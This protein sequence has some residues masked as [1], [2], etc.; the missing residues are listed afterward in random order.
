MARTAIHKRD[1]KRYLRAARV[2]AVGLALAAG[3]LWA[4]D[5]PGVNRA[6][7]EPSRVE[8]PREAP[9]TQP[10]LRPVSL[11]RESMEGVATRLEL[12]T[13]HKPAEAGPTG[14]T[15]AAPPQAAPSGPEWKY[16]GP[17]Y[18]GMSVRALVSVK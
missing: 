15:G 11:D 9:A 8:A 17:I 4:I 3:A 12:A 7:R 6:V 13:A 16:F 5:I 14:A 2:A 10:V 18:D 1:A